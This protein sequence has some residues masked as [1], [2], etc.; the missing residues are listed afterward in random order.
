MFDFV[1]SIPALICFIVGIA[2]LIVEMFTP[3]IGVPGIVGAL[4]LIAAVAVQANSL[5]QGLLLL[6]IVF[7][8]IAIFAIIFFRSASKGRLSKSSMVLKDRI[9]DEGHDFSALI[10]KTGVVLTD[11]RPAGSAKI[12]DKQYDVVAN[13]SFISVGEKIKVSEVDGMKIVVERIDF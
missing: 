9:T 13:S 11:L 2:F 8:I 1:L 4:L 3:G 10:G 7:I 6:I 12:D 5:E